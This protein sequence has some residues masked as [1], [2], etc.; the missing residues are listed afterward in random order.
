MYAFEKYLVKIYQTR[1]LKAGVMV[2]NP[3][4]I[5]FWRRMGFCISPTPEPLPDK[6]I[7]YRMSK[8]ID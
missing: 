7:V 6:T 3:L 2:N 1:L 5:K 4:A 8:S